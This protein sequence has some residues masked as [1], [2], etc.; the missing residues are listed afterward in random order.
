MSNLIMMLAAL[1]AL[2]GTEPRFEGRFTGETRAALEAIV[3]SARDAGLPTEPLVQR[4]LEGAS[5][6]AEP[7]RIVAVVRSLGERLRN[8]RS[9]LGPNA[10]E[11][12]L[13]AGASALYVGV[14]A[15]ALER[16]RRARAGG[17][18]AVPLVLLV[19]IIER[20]VPRDTAAALITSLSD[21]RVRDADYMTLRQ[22]I[23]SDIQSGVSPA[24]A[25]SARAR[26]VLVTRGLPEPQLPAVR[27]P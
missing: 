6:R 7:A 1:A 21:P 15:G 19:D 25:A 20:G 12:E 24:A 14:E 8:A 26:G 16:M 9:A 5:R 23:V 11:G 18:V 2:Q 22:S 10:S 17:S 13:V 4:A 3:Q 27:T